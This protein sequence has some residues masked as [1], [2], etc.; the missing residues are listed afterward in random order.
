M[1][2]DSDSDLILWNQW[3]TTNNAKTAFKKWKHLQVSKYAKL[4]KKPT[5]KKEVP[6]IAEQYSASNPPP[7]QAYLYTSEFNSWC[8]ERDAQNKEY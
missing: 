5:I 4:K 1:N 8:A 3:L 7:G 6:V 2:F